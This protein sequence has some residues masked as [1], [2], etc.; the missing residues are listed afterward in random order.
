VR[1]ELLT[2]I[3]GASTSGAKDHLW[4]MTLLIAMGALIAAVAGRAALLD[5]QRIASAVAAKVASTPGYNVG[6][7]AA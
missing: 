1:A 6:D 2:G 7:L 3:E 5:P 4:P